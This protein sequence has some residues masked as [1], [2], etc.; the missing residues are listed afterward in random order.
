MVAVYEGETTHSRGRLEAK[1]VF[2]IVN[3]IDRHLAIAV[4]GH[5]HGKVEVVGPRDFGDVREKYGVICAVRIAYISDTAAHIRSGID[6]RHC[7]AKRAGS[8]FYLFICLRVN[9][10]CSGHAALREQQQTSCRQSAQAAAQPGFL[11]KSHKYS[12]PL[13]AEK[14]AHLP[15]NNLLFALCSGLSATLS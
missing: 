5:R 15:S 13:S 2:V 9:R 4:N 7:L 6:R 8:V 12:P 14:A 1:Q 3:A 11:L 10:K